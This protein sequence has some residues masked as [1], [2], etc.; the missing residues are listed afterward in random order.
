MQTR[1][2]HNKYILCIDSLYQGI[3]GSWTSNGFFT[4]HTFFLNHLL[5][6]WLYRIEKTR[7]FIE[8]SFLKGALFLLTLL[9]AIIFAG[10]NTQMIQNWQFIYKWNKWFELRRIWKFSK[11]GWFIFFKPF[12]TFV[13]LFSEESNFVRDF[14]INQISGPDEFI[15]DSS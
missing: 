7:R 13:A 4:S 1:S 6:A 15:C 3:W 9:D 11:L 2:Y 5:F 10:T 8:A 12:W 14:T